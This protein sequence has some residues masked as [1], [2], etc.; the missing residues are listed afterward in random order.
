M[1]SLKKNHS[2]A[3]RYLE[4]VHMKTYS[5]QWI[6]DYAI[7]DFHGSVEIAFVLIGLGLW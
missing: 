1:G 4:H 2:C 6:Q 5:Q 7:M 3:W